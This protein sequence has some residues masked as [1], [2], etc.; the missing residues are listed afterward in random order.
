MYSADKA[1]GK[2]YMLAGSATDNFFLKYC[3]SDKMATGV[4]N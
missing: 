2:Q 4:L 1:K 3:D